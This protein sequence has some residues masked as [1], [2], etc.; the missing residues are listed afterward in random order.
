MALRRVHPS[1]ITAV[2]ASPGERVKKTLRQKVSVM[3]GKEVDRCKSKGN[4]AS[5]FVDEAADNHEPQEGVLCTIAEIFKEVISLSDHA[6]D[7]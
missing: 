4:I 7:Q 1:A 5:E 2:M 6:K 3:P